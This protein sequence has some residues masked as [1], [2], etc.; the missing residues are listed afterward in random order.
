[1]M[2]IKKKSKDLGELEI[3]YTEGKKVKNVK[4]KIYDGLNKIAEKIKKAARKVK[5]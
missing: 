4:E 5:E 3:K 2:K 1:M